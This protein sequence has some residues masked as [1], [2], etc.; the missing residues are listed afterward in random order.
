MVGA[1]ALGLA[2][3]EL[4]RIGWD[5]IIGHDDALAGRLRDG[6]RAIPGVTVLGPTGPTLPLAA[7]VVEGVHHASWP[8]A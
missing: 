5:T 7:F 2:I 4:E 3:E 6:L 8:P 1:V